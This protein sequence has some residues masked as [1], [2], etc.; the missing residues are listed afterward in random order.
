VV[1][2]NGGS[3]SEVD[4]AT[5]QTLRI[6]HDTKNQMIWFSGTL[7][8]GHKFSVGFP[9]AHIQV[10]FDQ[11]AA[12]MGWC[13]EPLCGSLVS[14]EGFFSNLRSGLAKGG[15]VAKVMQT[16]HTATMQ[17]TGT[18]AAHYATSAAQLLK[19]Q[20][21]M[22]GARASHALPAIGAQALAAVHAAHI[23]A[24][25][26]K[27]GADLSALRKTIQGMVANPTDPTARV[28]LAALQSHQI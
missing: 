7:A 8:D 21:G 25:K 9:I 15:P 28:T 27:S 12:S 14:V 10:T 18:Q 26:Q 1:Y 23:V 2:H 16:A 22:L 17:K 24:A 20:R 19:T 5:M 3:N 11:H 6:D 13:G 4:M